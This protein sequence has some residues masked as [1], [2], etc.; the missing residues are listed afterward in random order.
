MTNMVFD[1]H[2]D[3]WSDVTVKF[4]RG[5]SD[6]F[7]KYHYQR[8]QKGGIEGSILAMWIDPPYDKDPVLRLRQIMEAVKAETACCGDILQ[9][10]HDYEEMKEAK[11]KGLFYAFIGCEGLSGIGEDIEKIDMLYEF[12]VRCVSLTWNEQNALAAGAR[13][14]TESGLTALGVQAL[15]KIQDKHML[16]DVSHLNDKSFWDVMRHATGPVVAT[17]SDSRSLCPAPRNLT[18]EMIKEIVQTGG[19][20]GINAYPDFVSSR[21]EEKTVDMLAKHIEHIAD[22][23]GI[24]HVGFGFDFCEFLEEEAAASF[25]TDEETE[26]LYGLKDASETPNVLWAMQKIGFTK[27][28]IEK[29]S[30]QNWHQIIRK[31]I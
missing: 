19:M 15:H 10:V 5:E 30:Y 8:L 22:I 12:G 23:A 2:S 29:V 18:D 28:D 6:I 7:R 17:H 21:K 20:T 27:A 25:G 31:V 11:E 16:F 9:I 26:G 24:E 14:D 3:I 13:A 1:A 4:M